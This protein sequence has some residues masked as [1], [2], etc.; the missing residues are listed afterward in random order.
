[1]GTWQAICAVFIFIVGTLCLA[2]PRLKLPASSLPAAP[3]STSGRR[4][5]VS[6][7]SN[8]TNIDSVRRLPRPPGFSP[9]GQ[10]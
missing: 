10:P 5:N 2:A 3:P 6:R 7:S 1:M 9:F 4:L 8:T